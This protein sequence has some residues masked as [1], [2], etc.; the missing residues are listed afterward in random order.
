M[1]SQQRSAGIAPTI[2]SLVV[3]GGWS[4]LSGE[5]VAS[6][7]DYLNVI[8]ERVGFTAGDV[9]RIDQNADG[10]IDVR[11]LTLYYQAN[12]SDLPFV[13]FAES[14]TT[15]VADGGLI[16]IPVYFSRP[17]SGPLKYEISGAGGSGREFLLTGN[18][19]ELPDQGVVRGEVT[20]NGVVASIPLQLGELREVSE[21][22]P[23]II[24]LTT[25][26]ESPTS[27]PKYLFR[28]AAP[29]VPPAEGEP[30][31]APTSHLVILVSGDE[32]RFGGIL[33]VPQP[34]AVGSQVLNVSLLSNQTAR[35]DCSDSE[36]FSE[37][38]AVSVTLNPDGTFTWNG[39]ASGTTTIT[40]PKKPESSSVPTSRTINWRLTFGVP[41]WSDQNTTVDTPVTM[42]FSGL[43]ASS[44]AFTS[45]GLNLRLGKISQATEQPP[46]SG[47]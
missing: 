3:L 35:F 11:D 36:F 37:D 15:E 20:V 33:Q 23:I 12:P 10:T 14:Q 43:S 45:N 29:G 28:P 8:L 32:G 27:S 21:A 7:E 4:P 41:V 9:T 25:D 13:V 17:Y 30:R 26:A 34:S 5:I 31:L 47:D 1:Y 44:R 2:V 42:H 46:E 6:P 18:Q 39:E 22:R 16:Q 40:F 38:F 19:V 24:A